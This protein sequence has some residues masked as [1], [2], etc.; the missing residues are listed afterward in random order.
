MNRNWIRKIQEALEQKLTEEELL[1]LFGLSRT[2]MLKLLRSS[3]VRQEIRNLAEMPQYSCASILALCREGMEILAPEPPGG[4]LPLLYLHGKH[5]LYPDNFPEVLKASQMPAA[6]FYLEVLRIF[7]EDE[8]V[9]R[10]FSPILHFHKVE[11]NEL[12]TTDNPIEHRTFLEVCRKTWLFEFMRIG[13]EVTPFQ[14]L[15][16]IAGV[17]YTAMHVARQLSALGI[18]IDLPLI[19]AAAIGHDI[20]KFGCKEKENS[21]VP[22]LHYY[23]TDLFFKMY[24]MP[25]IGHIA[26][27]HSTWDLE[28]ENLSVESLVLIYADFRVKSTRENG[29]EQIVFY[30]LAD[31]FDI[32]L[33]KLDNVDEAKRERYRRVY[34][35]LADFEEYMRSLG[36]CTD[37]DRTAEKR[38]PQTDTALLY[39]EQIVQAYKWEAIAHNIRLMHVL[40][41]EKTFANILEVARSEKD[42]KNI[43]SYLNIFQEYYTYTNPKQKLLI[44]SLLYELLMHREGDIR[45]QAARL[46]GQLIIAYDTEYRKEIPD[47]WRAFLQESSSLELFR[48]YFNIVLVPDHKL[49]EQHRRWMMH[50]MEDLV[51]AALRAAKPSRRRAYLEIVLEAYRDFERDDFTAFTMINAVQKLP[52]S[53]CGEEDFRI[54]FAFVEHFAERKSTEIQVAV[55]RL[56][57]FCL[58]R[59][60]VRPSVRGCCERLFRRVPARSVVSIQYLRYQIGKL[61]GLERAELTI[62]EEFSFRKGVISETFLENLKTATPWICKEV[63]IEFLLYLIQKG[64]NNQPLHSTTHLGNLLMVSDC[65]DVRHSAGRALVEMS[66]YISRD[67]CNEV[68]VELFQGLE[69]GGSQFS[70]DIPAY[71]AELILRLQPEEVEEQILA[72]EQMVIQNNEQVACAA[73]DTLG[74]LVQNYPAYRERFHET[75]RVYQNRLGRILGLLL[76]GMAN[77]HERVAQEAVYVLGEYLFGSPLLSVDEKSQVFRFLAKKA[78]H[79]VKDQPENLLSFL[80]HAAALN[81]IYRFLSDYLFRYGSFHM[82]ENEKVAFFP[83][84]FDPFSLSHKGIV[85]EIRDLG[86]EVYLA[87][88]EFSWSK[89]TQ[90]KL[91][92]RKIAAMSVAD[93]NG[94]FLFPDDIPINIANEEDLK[95]LR[96]LF[97]GKD[98]S[99]VVGSDVVSNASAYKKPP[100]EF[101]IHQFPHIVFRRNMGDEQQRFEYPEI[102]GGVQQLSLP[103]YLEDISS[104]RIRESI[105]QNRDISQLIDPVVQSYIYENSLYLR[106]PQDKPVIRSQDLRCEVI[107]RLTIDLDRKLNGGRPRRRSDKRHPNEMAVVLWDDAGGHEPL[108]FC[109][110]RP[111]LLREIMDEFG[112]LALATKIREFASGKLVLITEIHSLVEKR[113]SLLSQWILTE[114]LA[115]ALSEEYTYCIYHGTGG[116][117]SRTEELLK[118]QGFRRMEHMG[119]DLV[120]AAALYAPTTLTDNIETVLKDPFQRNPNVM[121]VVFRAHRRMQEALTE[122]RPGH[123]VLSFDSRVMYHR[124]IDKITDANGVPNVPAIPPQLGDKMCVPFG[125]M[126]RNSV[127]P[128]TVTKALYTERVFHENM[129]GFTIQEYPNYS[130]LQTQIK[131]IRSFRRDII[132]VDDLLHKGYRLRELVPLLRKADLHIDRILV[133]ILTARGRDLAQANGLNADSV[134][135]IPNVHSWLVESTMYPFIGGDSVAGSSSNPSGLLPSVNLILPYVA[136]IFLMRD[137]REAAYRLSL[138]C[139]ENARDILRVLEEEYQQE[140]GRNLTLNRLSEAILSPTCP[141]KGKHVYYD[142]NLPASSYVEND[143]RQ[144]VR[145]R[146][147]TWEE[148][149]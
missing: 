84:T 98:L 33:N 50:R 89:K 91:V 18:E 27:N 15:G 1:H 46:M 17:H 28:L 94:V 72:L 124:M 126:F 11:K 58:N 63:N 110:L 60:Q 23:Y 59:E 32:I 61:L 132:L 12:A 115:Y 76:K 130:S 135:F 24:Q 87:I 143:I 137:S 77:Y 123:L 128:N 26:A 127:A 97:P 21:R 6:R 2:E 20:G 125:K 40:N 119:N 102:L 30:S 146:N 55:L 51:E 22:Y 73:L 45:S 142:G 103:V 36:V 66:A 121:E 39:G 108:A 114:A 95:L 35:K 99:I 14:T 92:C 90:P 82:A 52:F 85:Q 116:K 13:A 62:L 54:V 133:G 113:T 81:Q 118:R 136:P 64:R 69:N 8:P 122:F 25:V 117:D 9:S 112:D 107:H 93:D 105:D 3:H 106:E 141:D 148:K 129:D 68:T 57:Y 109:R 4:W 140:F 7:L 96:E 56:A 43:R 34:D 147:I 16:H 47:G 78:L 74:H 41:V 139:L 101:S 86:Y 67:Q 144:L 38:L 88:D 71:L 131:T 5:L 79:I 75:K 29:K 83:G 48:K 104:T 37:L 138:V 100:S 70:K 80:I 65:D 42:W 134:Y 10:G 49:T 120:M 149:V 111:I 145:L 53:L 31:S 19:S 44:I